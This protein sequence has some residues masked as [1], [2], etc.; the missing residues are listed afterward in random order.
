MKNVEQFYPVVGI[1]EKINITLYVLEQKL[2][3]FFGGAF[4]TYYENKDVKLNSNINPEKYPVSKEITSSLMKNMTHE[5]E[6]YD[7]C[8]QRL[9]NQYELLMSNTKTFN[10]DGLREN[11]WKR[12]Q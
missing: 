2:P 10:F 7:F 6:F 1:T 11:S 5:I 8:K 3:Q 12:V 4:E 9:Y